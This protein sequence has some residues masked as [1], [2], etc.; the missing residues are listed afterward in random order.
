M[1]PLIVNTIEQAKS[2]NKMVNS[3]K[4]G[5]ECFSTLNISTSSSTSPVLIMTCHIGI[6][7]NGRLKFVVVDF[8]Q[9]H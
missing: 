6:Y 5:R 9:R 7:A 4:L 1:L 3:G 8:Q 2:P